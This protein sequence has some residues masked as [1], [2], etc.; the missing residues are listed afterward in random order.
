MHNLGV[1]TLLS[2]MAIAFL[3][4]LYLSLMLFKFDAGKAFVA[5]FIPGYVFLLAKRHG[6]FSHFLKFYVLGLVLLVI[7]GVILS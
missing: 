4:Q 3:A 6:L 7:G 5:L 2:G 1:C